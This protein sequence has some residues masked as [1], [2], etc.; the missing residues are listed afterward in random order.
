M[1]KLRLTLITL[2][3]TA[4]QLFGQQ[5]LDEMKLVD[6]SNQAD[7]KSTII[8]NPKQALL[9]IKTQIPGI[10]FQS[11]NII[12]NVKQVETGLYRL[13]LNPGTHRIVF[14]AD[15]FISNKQRFYFNPKDVKG[16]QIR[17][18]L[19]AKQKEDKNSGIIV[20]KSQPNEAE[21]FINGDFYGRTP[22]IGKLLSGQYELELKKESH[23]DYRDKVI[24]LAG[25][26]IPLN[27]KIMP[28]TQV[29]VTTE[30][31]GATV[32][33][34]SKRIGITP[35]VF[36]GLFQGKH[37]LKLS[38]ENYVD[39]D[40][41]IEIKTAKDSLSIHTK[42]PERKSELSI[43]GWPNNADIYLGSDNLGNIPLQKH[44]VPFGKH[45]LRVENKGYQTYQKELNI[46]NI[47]PYMLNIDLQ[48]KSK[49]KALAFS[50]LLPGS[51]QLYLDYTLKGILL[52]GAT[53]ASA[54]AAFLMYNQYNDDLN[55]F[56]DN[57]L[58]YENNIDLNKMTELYNGIQDS[59][60]NMED[61][62]K[63]ANMFTAIAA[64]LY[65]INLADIL[66]FA[67]KGRQKQ[68]KVS[69]NHGQNTLSLQYKF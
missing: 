33:I 44:I 10:R 61:S 58:L 25:Q 55:S 42:M 3:L 24:I 47:A 28:K 41:T 16:I 29:I 54:T 32:F 18:E 8:R 45:L 26:T 48:P 17:V 31:P 50:A 53:I 2:L 40:K 34:N 65:V 67:P 5:F 37:Q 19:A 6:I 68:V 56:N 23:L 14:Q 20:I 12:Q 62:A 52:G 63:N 22:Y 38:L 11:N 49:W 13:Y 66:I 39:V 59:Y 46:N 36:D 64:G 51:G 69:A 1:K 35:Y 15:G 4:V 9:I 7:I 30:P 43:T 57:K 60:K 27:I 21:I